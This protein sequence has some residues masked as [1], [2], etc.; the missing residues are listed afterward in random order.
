[1]LQT[2]STLFHFF[3]SA[4]FFKSAKNKSQLSNVGC[5]KLNH[6]LIRNANGPLKFS[7]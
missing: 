5:L 4:S 7:N 2:R 3:F 6:G 1:M